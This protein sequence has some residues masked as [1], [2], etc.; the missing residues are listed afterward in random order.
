MACSRTIGLSV[1]LYIKNTYFEVEGWSRALDIPA[2]DVDSV[3]K[4]AHDSNH[5]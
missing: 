5:V 3:A 4:Y 2:E 1:S